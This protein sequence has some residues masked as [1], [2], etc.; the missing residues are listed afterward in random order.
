MSDPPADPFV[1]VPPEV[2]VDLSPARRPESLL[3]P[4]AV[5]AATS[6]ASLIAT[7][8][9]VAYSIPSPLVRALVMIGCGLAV[10]VTGYFTPPPRR[11]FRKGDQ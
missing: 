5:P 1:S 9:V 3:P 11:H 4:R 8:A 2:R 10:W 6:S 7:A